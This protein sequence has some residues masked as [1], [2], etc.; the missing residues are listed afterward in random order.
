MKKFILLSVVFMCGYSLNAANHQPRKTHKQLVAEIL[1]RSEQKTSERQARPSRLHHES[2]P[3]HHKKKH[4]PT[5]AEQI[6]QLLGKEEKPV[7]GISDKETIATTIFLKPIIAKYVASATNKEP[8]L[9]A[10]TGAVAWS[11]EW[12]TQK[13][14]HDF[15]MK[16]KGLI[17][18]IKKAVAELP[19]KDKEFIKSPKSRDYADMLK[20]LRYF[21]SIMVFYYARE[22]AYKKQMASW[23]E[24]QIQWVKKMSKTVQG[25]EEAAAK[26]FKEAFD[27][28]VVH[29]IG[30]PAGT[31]Q[32]P[33]LSTRTE[34]EPEQEA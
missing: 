25:Y 15:Y 16:V 29:G 10:E 24:E 14:H 21:T 9:D 4:P 19:D 34:Q 22:D 5:P 23:G 7:E 27:H 2:N 12:K 20:L 28:S 8:V 1:E 3:L 26:L 6:K 30:V 13:S 33:A 17:N 11:D 32:K 18:E 31:E